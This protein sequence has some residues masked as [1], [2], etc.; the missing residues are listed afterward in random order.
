MEAGIRLNQQTVNAP[1]ISGP[2]KVAIILD[3][4]RADLDNCLKALLDILVS[5]RLLHDDR[6]VNEI[7]MLH[8]PNHKGKCSITVESV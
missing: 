2:V 6:N 7:H 4:G 8:D 5:H 3:K 1:M